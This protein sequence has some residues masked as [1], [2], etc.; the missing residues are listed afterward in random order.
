MTLPTRLEKAKTF[1][2][3]HTP[4][5]P[6]VLYNIWD[7]GSAVAVAEAGARAIATGSWSVAAAQGAKDGEDLPLP[8][9]LAVARGV[10]DSVSLP[11]TVDFEAGY[12]VEPEDVA[13]NVGALLD[14]GAV[15]LNLEDGIVG[16]PGFY[17]VQAQT[18]RLA[19]ARR[20]AETAKLPLFVNARIDLFLRE[21]NPD[22]HRDHLDEA[23]ERAAAYMKAGASGVFAPG[24]SDLAL[25]ERFCAS[26]PGPVNVMA[27]PGG[28][29]LKAFAAAGVA[30]VSSGPFPYRA[31]IDALKTAA[32]AFHPAPVS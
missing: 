6:L 24:L 27:A 5:D 10:V 2:D 23:L 16:E 1:A 18:A 12:A 4:G 11:V 22:K 29:S 26:A 13:T 14:T 20:A 3:L 28:P 25:I 19:A 8:V 21:P 15:G 32:R 7:P 31:M 9:A 17:S 30:R